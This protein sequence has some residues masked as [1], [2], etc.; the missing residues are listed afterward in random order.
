METAFPVHYIIITQ[1]KEWYSFHL[2]KEGSWVNPENAGK[3]AVAHFQKSP[4]ITKFLE[5]L[6]AFYVNQGNIPALSPNSVL[7]T[8]HFYRSTKP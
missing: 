7:L 1:P 8:S 6:V 4:C 2:P 5:A 3:G